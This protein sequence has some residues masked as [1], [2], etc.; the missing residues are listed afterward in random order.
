MQLALYRYSLPF[1]QPLMFKGQRLAHREGLLVSIN[2]QWGEIAPLPGFSNESLAE[3]E[4][5]SL[6]CL[7]AMSRG[8]KSPQ[9]CLR[10]SLGLT[11]LSALGQTTF[12][13]LCRPTRYPGS[14]AELI[15]SFQPPIGKR[16][17][18]L[19]SS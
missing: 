1:R 11:A 12:L 7:T 3:A 16:R 19:D 9:R 4:A 14:P 2:G 10:C 8:E 18:R 6:A 5:E 15:E 13:R 17:H